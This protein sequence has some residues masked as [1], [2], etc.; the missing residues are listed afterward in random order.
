MGSLFR[1]EEMNLCQIFLQ[2]EAAYACVSELG[3]LG[4]VQFKDLNPDMNAFQRKFVSEIMRCDEMERKLRYIHKELKKDGMKIPDRDENP[5]APAP[6]EMIDLEA[7]FEKIESELKEVNTNAEALRRN[8]LELTELKEVLKKTQIFFEEHGRH[9]IVDDA[10]HALVHDEG[11]GFVP[12]TSVQLGFVAGVIPR[13]KVPA[14]ERLLWFANR[15]NTFLKYD[16]IDQQLEDPVTGDSISKCVFLIFFQGEQLKARVRKICEGFKATLY[17]CPET[18]HERTEMLNGVS[19]RLEDLNLVL[20]QTEDHRKRVL[21]SAQK[22]IRPWIIKV[23]KI[24][25]IYHT[26]NMCNY[27][28]SHNSLIAEC[29][30]PVSGLEEIQ[31]ALK[32]GTELSGSTVPSILHRMQ[33]KET[34]PT[35]FKTNKFTHV[36]QAIIDAYGIACYQEVNPAPY[37][38]ISFPFLFAVMFGDF[39]HGFIMFLAGLWMVLTEKKLLAKKSDNEIANMFI[40]GRYIITM[41][42]LFSIYT[43]LIYNDIFS[44]SVNIFQSSWHPN[45]DFKTLQKEGYSSR[46]LN[47]QEHFD[48]TTGPYPFGIDPIWQASLNKITFNNSLKMKLSVI[49][50]VSQMLLGVLLSFVN[51]AYFRRPLNIFCEFIPQLIFLVCLFG[52]LVAVVVYKWIAFNADCTQYAPQLIIQFINM[53]LLSYTPRDRP[54]NFTGDLYACSRIEPTSINATSQTVFYEYQQ[55]IQIG[56]VLAALLM[57]PVMLLVKPLILKARHSSRVKRRDRLYAT[58]QRTLIHNEEQP[59]QSDDTKGVKGARPEAHLSDIE[60][61]AVTGKNMNING[62]EERGVVSHSE[63]GILG[64]EEEEN[65]PQFEFGEVFILQAIHTIEYCLGCISHTASYLRLWALSLAHAQLS[66]VLWSM[67]FRTGLT[68]DLPY[69]GGILIWAIFAA[70]AGVTVAVLLLMEGLSAFLH[71]IRLHWVEFNSKFY[72]GDGYQFAPYSFKHLLDADLDE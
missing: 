49:F 54:A 3:E 65:I 57:I 56:M 2:S 22:E 24:K 70:F 1:S 40:G 29:W 69:V 59:E 16:E 47:P 13:E 37:A 30:T 63:G 58:S 66:E 28:V 10:Q 50:G 51:H 18:T 68:M 44:K 67:L 23:K 9:G 17:P 55:P 35:Y 19:T 7:T 39:G 52:Y 62:E 4:L 6:K 33:T 14:F 71:T 48:N 53:F 38:I 34:P 20:H 31:Q 11:S 41:M 26:L 72:V 32:H 25:A 21:M 60:L 36:F 27:D 43:G 42:G 45:Y 12:I 46:V 8:Y 5:K 15:G 64:H 61:G